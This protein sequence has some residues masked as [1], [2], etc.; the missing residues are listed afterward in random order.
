MN[1]RRLVTDAAIV[2]V[3]VTATA[4]T[5]GWLWVVFLSPT[6]ATEKGPIEGPSAMWW[7]ATALGLASMLVRGTYPLIALAGSAGMSLAHLTVTAGS[8]TLLLAATPIAMY[9]VASRSTRRLV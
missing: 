3:L 9:A 7:A 5:S 4:G 8:P 6:T 1:V 2:G